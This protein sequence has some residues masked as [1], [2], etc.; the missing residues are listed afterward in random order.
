MSVQGDLERLE[1]EKTALLDELRQWSPDRLV[2]RP[3]EDCWSALEVLDHIVLTEREIAGAVRKGLATPQRVGV[4]DRLGFAMVERIFMTDRRVK[5]PKS[6][7][8][9]LP[10]KDLAL[11]G[12][13]ARW[14]AGRTELAR[15][16]QECS[17]LGARDGIF[18]HPVAGQMTIGQVLRFFSVHIHHHR[19]QLARIQASLPAATWPST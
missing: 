6:V 17:G 2:L 8:T 16:L 19:F 9:I 13:A 15:L 10:G 11:D 5:A 4:R 1:A 3:A 7:T 18:R 14:D 12:I